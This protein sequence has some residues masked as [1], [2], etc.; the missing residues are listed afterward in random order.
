MSTTEKKGW[1]SEFDEKFGVLEGSPYGA[2]QMFP[3]EGGYCNTSVDDIKAFLRE[4]IASSEQRTRNE[5]VDY[6]KKVGTR[7]ENELVDA[8]TG[9]PLDGTF[10]RIYEGQIEEAR[11]LPTKLK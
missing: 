9:E 5:V 10:Y 7:F 1:E 4:T 11:N 3:C 2:K 6:I 8:G